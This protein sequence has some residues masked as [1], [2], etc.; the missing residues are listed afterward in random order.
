MQLKGEDASNRY[1]QLIREVFGNPKGEE[2]LDMMQ[3]IYGDRPSYIDGITVEEMV[4]REGE[5]RIFLMI[6]EIMK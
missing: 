6:K 2:L 4:A 3:D 5:R 1:V